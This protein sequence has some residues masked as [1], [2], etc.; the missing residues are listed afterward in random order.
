MGFEWRVQREFSVIGA[1]DFT[2]YHYGGPTGR[3]TRYSC[4]WSTSL[5]A[6]EQPAITVGY[7]CYVHRW[8]VSDVVGGDCSVGYA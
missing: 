6:P 4:R 5:T 8:T 7:D 3:R 1:Y 2:D